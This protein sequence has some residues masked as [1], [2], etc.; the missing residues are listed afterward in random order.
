MMA[1]AL[2]NTSAVI[3]LF[4]WLPV[5]ASAHMPAV[6]LVLAAPETAPGAGHCGFELAL[7]AMI[8]G[9]TA[10]HRA[11]LSVVDTDMA[12]RFHSVSPSDTKR[13]PT[14]LVRQEN[15][16]SFFDRCAIRREPPR[17][18]KAGDKA[19]EEVCSLIES[20]ASMIR[21]TSLRSGFSRAGISSLWHSSTSFCCSSSVGRT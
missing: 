19:V 17:Q 2:H 6:P 13:A 14:L 9:D 12:I 16:R 3:S 10:A 21:S 20:W 7:P 5:F 11:K 15:E 4:M 18:F 1:G 8:C